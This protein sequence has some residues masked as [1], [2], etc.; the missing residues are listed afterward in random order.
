MPKFVG[1]TPVYRRHGEADADE[2]RRGTSVP[3]ESIRTSCRVCGDNMEMGDRLDSSR[4]TIDPT[5]A[6]NIAHG[7]SDAGKKRSGSKVVRV[8]GRRLLGE[9]ITVA[10]H[11]G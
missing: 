2:G 5:C 10:P 8:E 3:K 1:L 9:L 7:A 4:T 6:L 11:R